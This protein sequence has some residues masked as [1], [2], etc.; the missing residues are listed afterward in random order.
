MKITVIGTGYVGL[1]LGACFAEMGNSV[2]CLDVDANKINLL[3]NGVITMY[4]PGLEDLVKRNVESGNL[5]FTTD[6]KKAINESDIIFICVGTP[7]DK[8]GSADLKYVLKV[9]NQIGETMDKHK[10]VVGKSTIP[11][12]TS[13]K[14]QKTIA[15]ALEKRGASY[16]FDVA[17]SPEFMKEGTAVDDM[18]KPD[19]VV[20]G[21]DNDVVAL[22]L[23]EL[24]EPFTLN[25][26]PII[27]T[28][29]RSAEMIKYASNCFL[30]TKITFMNQ[31]A[32]ICEK[33]GANVDE[34]RRGMGTDLRI[35]PKFLYAGTGF[36]GSCF[37][38]DVRALY[39]T[40]K[41]LGVE[42]GLMAEV[43]NYNVER[44]HKMKELLI[45]NTNTKKV[46]IW[47][48]AFKPET[49]D[50]R[51]APAITIIDD[52]LKE[53]YEINV[54]DPMATENMK[55]IYPNQIKY[56]DNQYECLE[57]TGALL[58]VTEW[59]QFRQPHFDIMKDKMKDCVI[60]DG[61][62]Q[63]NLDRMKQIGFKY[64]SI[65]RNPVLI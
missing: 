60:I 58:I 27:L 61:R 47:G 59:K 49:D 24:F 19:R 20:I 53:G 35:S 34:V 41:S 7:S 37:P 5:C 16:N 65:G 43:I 50:I 22:L 10:I 17:F 57:D 8:D 51:E 26:R 28:D 30:A 46:A 3:N 48:L 42:S 56:F 1:P 62:N 54:Y 40:S 63:Y 9:A 31:V 13:E 21:A 6:Y 44:P 12:G 23:K 38:K 14:I 39:N 36:G 33:V 15:A 18:M 29:V 55:Q 45:A 4:E 32:D 25:N 64:F 11:V 2:I 52:L